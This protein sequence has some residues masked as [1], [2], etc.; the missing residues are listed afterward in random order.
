[1]KLQLFVGLCI[2]AAT[3]YAA[4]PQLGSSGRRAESEAQRETT[5]EAEH[6]WLP[7]LVH[8]DVSAVGSNESEDFR[9]ITPSMMMEGQGHLRSLRRQ[10]AHGGSV[11]IDATFAV[12]SQSIKVYGDVAVVSDICSFTGSTA[13]EISTGRYW[14]TEVW[15]REGT[16]WKIVHMQIAALQHG[17]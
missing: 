14:Q 10:V 15:H 4:G 16:Q 1:M 6:R 13:G 5:R 9:L 17:M 12:S 11:G 7:A 3:S 2:L 8:A